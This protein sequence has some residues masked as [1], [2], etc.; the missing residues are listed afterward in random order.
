MIVPVTAP[1]F[2]RRLGDHGALRAP[3]RVS[4]NMIDVGTGR[5]RAGWAIMVR[6][7]R[8]TA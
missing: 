7:V 8:R 3:D 5:T 2:L 6:C 1:W 4:G